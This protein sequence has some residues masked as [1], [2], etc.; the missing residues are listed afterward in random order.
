MTITHLV[1]AAAKVA[2]TTL[3]I[4]SAVPV[5]V[6][7]NLEAE[8]LLAVLVRRAVGAETL[9]VV[10][11]K[12]AVGVETLTAVMV[13]TTVEVEVGIPVKNQKNPV[14]F[15]DRDDLKGVG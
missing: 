8:A 11:V 12:R 7:P 9:K 6:F 13:R 5:P 15:N 14:K 10:L 3:Q 1:V 4:L 2:T